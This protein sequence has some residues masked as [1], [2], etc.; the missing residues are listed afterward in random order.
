MAFNNYGNSFQQTTPVVFN[1]IIINALVY[2]AQFMFDGADE[3]ITREIALFPLF[4]SPYFKPYQVVTHMFAHGGLFHLLF[5]MLVLWMFG[6]MLERVWGPKR[7]FIFYLVCGLV[8]LAWCYAS[9][10]KLY[11]N[12]FSIGYSAE[13]GSIGRNYGIICSFC[14]PVSKY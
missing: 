3:K 2:F 9:F 8:Q 4:K 13:C 11:L 7:F 12:E 5:N 14:I 1:L 10:W 6:S